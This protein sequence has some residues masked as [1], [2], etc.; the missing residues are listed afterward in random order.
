MKQHV[1]T[2]RERWVP[3]LTTKQGQ[4]QKELPKLERQTS[5]TGLNK[6]II[7]LLFL[8]YTD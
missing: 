7:H 2:C 3:R 5:S 1:E 8:D 6:L 4:L